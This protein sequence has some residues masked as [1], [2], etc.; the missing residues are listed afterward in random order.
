MKQR[1]PKQIVVRLTANVLDALEVH[2]ARLASERPGDVVTVS[3][4][5]R[6]LI[7]RDVPSPKKRARPKS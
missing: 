4:A 2:R 3:D 6:N 7:M 5:I 1:E